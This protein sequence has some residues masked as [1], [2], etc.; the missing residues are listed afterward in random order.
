[1]E[2]LTGKIK[3]LIELMGF[4]QDEFDLNYDGENKRASVVITSPVLEKGSLPLFLSSLE[5]V[6]NMI[7]RKAGEEEI[8]LDIN[9]YRREREKL[10]VELAKAAAHKALVTRQDVEL[11]PMNGYERRLVHLEISTRP[12]L[13]TESL[14]EG[15]ER[16]VVIKLL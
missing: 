1:M 2:T 15:R 3:N 8:S 4:A 14:G 16:R 9:N 12:D 11:P 13:K 7:L 10:I 5:L 6:V